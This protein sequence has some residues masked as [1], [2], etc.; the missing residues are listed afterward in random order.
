MV[1]TQIRKI[2]GSTVFK[3]LLLSAVVLV[4]VVFMWFTYEIIGQLRD[5]AQE[6]VRSYVK[7]WV[8]AVDQDTPSSETQLIFDEII[9]QANFPII[10]ASVER[11]PN[12]WR[13]LP[14]IEDNE[15][16]PETLEKVREMMGDMREEHGEEKI[17]FGP[18][19]TTGV[20]P[21]GV[22]YFYH[23]D[24][25]LIEILKI[26][27]YVQIAMVLSVLFIGFVGFTNIKRS[28]ERHIW[29][30]MAKETAHQ[31]GT[32]ISSLMGW[33]EIM[34]GRLSAGDS[35]GPAETAQPSTKAI[36]DSMNAE[37][38]RLRQV[39]NRFGKIGS[40]PEMLE[41]D[42][43]QTVRMTVEYFRQR[44]PFDGQG[45]KLS[46]TEEELP[47]V[48]FN[49][50]LLEWTVENLIKNALE[51]VDSRSGQI[52]LCS[53]VSTDGRWIRLTVC[54][55]GRGV[56]LGVQRKVFRPGFS[57]KKRGWGLGLT[58]ARR[59]VDEYHGGKLVLL[60]SSPGE[61]LFQLSLPAGR[62]G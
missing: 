45:A 18:V 1:E 14:G 16:G 10:V 32:P 13:N 8:R 47:P 62:R 19:D 21:Q 22:N 48:I 54:D 24:S 6:K 30:G 4:S 41:L 38:D 28:D 7:L 40:A 46:F 23:G 31:L 27:P 34:R 35:T 56:P 12:F 43:N 59:I 36:L 20:S 58:L 25:R 29:V 49:P 15:R 26:A 50:E 3:L 52:E 42:F 53:R 5:E 39:A 33:L 61:T 2:S 60:K 37:T 9:S 55:N 44:L 51:A 11:E 57:T 17:L